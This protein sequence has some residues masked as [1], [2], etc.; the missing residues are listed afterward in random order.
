[1]NILLITGGN[2]SE[3]KISFMSAEQVEEALREKGHN[4]IVYDL[5]KGYDGIKE[6][7]SKS[8]VLFPVLHGEE[9]EGGKLHKFLAQF[10]K[11]M[12]GTNNYKGLQNGWYKIPFKQFCQKHNILTS[13]WSLVKNKKDIL[14]FGFPSVLK[15]SSGGSS[16]EVVILKSIQDLN[17]YSVKKLLNSRH[18]LFIER[19]IQGVEATVGVLNGKALPVIEIVP[20]KGAWF[21]Y[22]NKYWGKTQEIPFAPSVSKKIQKEIQDI[23]V[24]IHSV[25]DLGSYSRIDFIVAGDKAYAL[26]VNTIPGLTSESLL[27][28]AAKAAGIEFS[29]LIEKLIQ[30]A[31]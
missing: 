13:E 17:L 9:G 20:P 26:E 2:S 8:Q 7:A 21:D 14:D 4:V 6:L 23:A 28:K 3:R 18:E 29:N 1:M 31:V 16:R 11:P 22:K 15:A 25:L 30:L 24:S 27:P 12:V 10:K 19:F 5:K